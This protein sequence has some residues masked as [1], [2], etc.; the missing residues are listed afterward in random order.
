MGVVGASQGRHTH[1]LTYRIARPPT[2]TG[3]RTRRQSMKTQSPVLGPRPGSLPKLKLRQRTRTSSSDS[4]CE[5]G[6]ESPS[7]LLEDILTSWTARLEGVLGQ[8][9]ARARELTVWAKEALRLNESGG[10]QSSHL[11][12][13]GRT[14]TGIQSGASHRRG[15]V[16][17]TLHCVGP[18]THEIH[19]TTKPTNICAPILTRIQQPTTFKQRGNFLEHNYER[20]Q[21]G[22]KQH[23]PA[24]NESS[25]LV[26]FQC[27]SK[28]SKQRS[29]EVMFEENQTPTQRSSQHIQRLQIHI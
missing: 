27:V 17:A 15:Q 14:Y 19:E 28:C 9:V 1:R 8:E 16:W 23:I 10:G 22:D 2:N 18:P 11:G 24:N 5:V 29:T 7:D 21:C 6:V 25:S 3:Q 4:G 26:A 12:L 13:E 20:K